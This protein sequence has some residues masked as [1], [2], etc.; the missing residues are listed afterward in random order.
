[1]AIRA[2]LQAWR[3]GAGSATAF[4]VADLTAAAMLSPVLQPPKI[5]YPA[6]VERPPYLQNYR[7]MVLRYPAARWGQRSAE[8]HRGHSAEVSRPSADA[9]RR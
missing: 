5:Q 8:L 7:A 2:A 9:N 1:M 3:A 6:P 4:T